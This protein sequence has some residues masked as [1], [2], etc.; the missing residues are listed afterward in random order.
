MAGF[1][2]SILLTELESPLPI[3]EDA[4]ETIF[5]GKL[6]YLVSTTETHSLG[7]DNCH[8]GYRE[9]RRWQC[10]RITAVGTWEDH[11]QRRITEA[12]HFD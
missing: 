9:Y 12:T 7:R 2:L 11:K 6:S 8:F 1:R 5:R 10:K 3:N 4:N